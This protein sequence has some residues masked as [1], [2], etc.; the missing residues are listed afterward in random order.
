MHMDIPDDQLRLDT[1][2]VQPPTSQPEKSTTEDY[3][4]TDGGP[5]DDGFMPPEPEPESDRGGGWQG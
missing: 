3:G 5:E 1:E 4:A 2:V